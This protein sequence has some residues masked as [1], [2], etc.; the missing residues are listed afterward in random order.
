LSKS[1]EEFQGRNL[2]TWFF[3]F[4]MLFSGGLI[5]YF[6]QIRNIGLLDS[7]WVMIIP[8]AMNVFNMIILMNCFRQLPA[9]LLEAA[10]ID[11]AHHFLVFTKICLPL[12]MPTLA[13]LALFSMV[14]HWNDWFTGMILLFDPKK[15]PLQTYIRAL[16]LPNASIED[17][18]R[19]SGTDIAMMRQLSDKNFK[20]A[21]LFIATIPIL[22]SY[23]F[24]QKY[25]VKGIIVGSIKG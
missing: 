25:F 24:L 6:L 13:T 5:P 10:E 8:S 1:K 23:P 21:Q 3:F 4:T 19:L 2:F 15:W 9:S 16:T 22:C 11:G 17:L 7:F 18:K 14:F 20:A 12:S